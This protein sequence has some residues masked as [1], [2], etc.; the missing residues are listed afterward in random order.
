MKGGLEG[1]KDRNQNNYT[2]LALDY[3]YFMKLFAGPF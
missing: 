2:R 3:E 1:R